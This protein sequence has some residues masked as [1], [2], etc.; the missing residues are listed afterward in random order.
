MKKELKKDAS[1]QEKPVF[2]SGFQNK[3]LERYSNLIEEKHR[4]VDLGMELSSE[5]DELRAEIKRLADFLKVER[6]HSRKGSESILSLES[7]LKKLRKTYVSLEGNHQEMSAYLPKLEAEVKSWKKEHGV[8]L[9]RVREGEVLIRESA[10]QNEIVKKRLGELEK[11][12]KKD[13]KEHQKLEK[14]IKHLEEVGKGQD[15]ALE[16]WTSR[17]RE[18]ELER[19]HISGH[20]SALMERVKSL[21]DETRTWD[22]EH[23]KLIDYVKEVERTELQGREV[24]ER[25]ESAH[26]ELDQQRSHLEEEHAKLCEVIHSVEHTRHQLQ[27]KHEELCEYVII[28][29]GERDILREERQVFLEAKERV[30]GELRSLQSRWVYR[31]YRWCK[32]LVR[33]GS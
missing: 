3:L 22:A 26:N 9:E 29:E 30:E 33:P 14:Y 7:E 13:K 24:I 12:S 16:D 23:R 10:A 18:L 8:L 28:I 1:K 21:E 27:T 5:R 11:I 6:E 2:S 20:H 31:L 32:G 19:N 25:M 15:Q 17:Y 4:A